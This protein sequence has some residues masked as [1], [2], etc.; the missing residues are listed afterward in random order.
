[1]WTWEQRR[2]KWKR[3]AHPAGLSKLLCGVMRKMALTCAMLVELGTRSTGSVAFDAGISPRRRRKHYRVALVAVIPTKSPWVAR[4]THLAAASNNF[5]PLEWKCLV[6]LR[7]LRWF[8]SVLQNSLFRWNVELAYVN[9]LIVV[10]TNRE[11]DTDTWTR[12]RLKTL[13]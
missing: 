2:S 13:K 8:L 11:W 4:L 7:L 10:Y 3:N 12:L 6:L 1:M 9:R 5:T